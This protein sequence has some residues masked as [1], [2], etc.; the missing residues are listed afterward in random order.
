MK[1]LK[2]EKIV[3]FNPRIQKKIDNNTL[4]NSNNNSFNN[5]TNLQKNLSPKF[6]TTKINLIKDKKNPFKVETFAENFSNENIV[7]N[8]GKWTLKEHI[9]F[10]QALDQFGMKS[11]KF[12]KIIKTRTATQI[13]THCQKIFL[14][15]KNCKDEELGIDFTLENIHNI[16]DIIN[17]IKSV[18]KNFDV[19]NILLYISGKYSSNSDTKKIKYNKKSF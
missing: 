13:R 11:E 1:V 17:H 16:K 14:K 8:S 9:Q 7:P 18:N 10:L 2:T 5:I 4:L 3:N 6:L 12:S 19:V 15:L